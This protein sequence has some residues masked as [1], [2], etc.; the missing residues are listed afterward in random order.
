MKPPGFNHHKRST[1]A[2]RV[3]VLIKPQDCIQKTTTLTAAVNSPFSPLQKAKHQIT[4]PILAAELFPSWEP[5]KSCKSPFRQE[6]NP[7]FSVFDDGRRWKD[8]T[9]GEGGDIVDFLAKA[10]GFDRSSAARELI[11]LARISPRQR[12]LTRSSVTSATRQSPRNPGLLPT[13]MTSDCL[14]IWQEGIRH[15]RGSTLSQRSIEQ[16]RGW[17]EGTVSAM[18][19]D[20]LMGLPIV[21]GQRAIGFA[22]QHPFR[23]D[24]GL[25]RVRPVGFHYTH[26]VTKGERSQWAY[27]PSGAKI[28]ALPFVQGAGFLSQ[29]HT[30]LVTEGQWDSI[31]I[32]AAGGWLT[33]DTTWPEQ[34]T[35]FGIRGSASWRTLVGTWSPYWRKDA[36]FTV[37]PDADEAGDKWLSKGNLVETLRQQGH[38]VR[39]LRT[40]IDGAKD[41]NDV[42]RTGAI[43]RGELELMLGRTIL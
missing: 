38:P 8:F 18:A 34:V 2:S 12:W 43:T 37:L 35:V 17:Q 29:A 33:G 1:P 4:I 23:D 30:I 36:R 27:Y 25:I 40:S 19:N 22:V 20:E 6:R 39:V 42:H 26:A 16:W 21:K 41:V 13:A 32:A 28:P 15:L 9:T 5:R 11:T 3:G 31:T 7:S 24:N 14:A 10:K